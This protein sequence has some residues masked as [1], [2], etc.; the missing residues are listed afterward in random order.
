M[1]RQPGAR[2]DPDRLRIALPMLTLV[3]GSMG[4]S[5]LY[6]RELTRELARHPDLDVTTI[7]SAAAA[8]FS[9]GGHEV[10]A[11]R[12]PGR[13]STVGRLLNIAR[14]AIPE[15]DVRR[16]VSRADVVHYPLTVPVP[17]RP[18][19]TPMVQTV[20]DVQ[21]H[22]LAELFSR[23]ERAYRALVYDRP[24]R[25]ADV[26]VT[27]SE[28]CRGRLVERLG[29]RPDRVRVAHLGVDADAFTA[30]DGPRESFVLYPARGWPHK[31]HG[32]LVAAVE[33]LRVE[34][35]DLRLVLT[36]GGGDALG[37]LPDWVEHRGLVPEEELADLYRRAA[38][39]AFPSRYEG[40]G[41]PPLEAMASGCPVA[42]ASSGSLPE[43]CGDAAVLFDPDDVR[44]MAAAIDTAIAARER[45]APLG[46][47]RI[48]TFTWQACAAVHADVYREL[49]GG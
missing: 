48:R 41:L 24:A 29:L 18:R 30:N 32:R 21:H 35:P 11:T 23:P 2:L 36:G 6:A 5:E 15:A 3:P 37:P 22:D 42:A 8:G 25:H 47:R 40:F 28:F 33:R 19:S 46:M 26:V 1:S 20:L 9:K 31:N 43:V 12:Q 49:A 13:G 7:V 34:R 16:P 45:L 38:C 17:L 27:I 4:G 39:L 14:S 10:V 44:A